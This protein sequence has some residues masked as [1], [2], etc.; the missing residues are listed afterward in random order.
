MSKKITIRDVAR[1]AGVS[2]SLVSMVLNAKRDK[3]GN[4]DC[5]VNKDTARKVIDVIKRLGYRPNKAAASLRS[6]RA[7]TIGVVVPDISNRF[8]SHLCRYIETVAAKEGY[9]VQFSSFDE[10]PDNFSEAIETYVGS[11]V[12]GLVVAPCLGGDAAIK[13]AVD[14][15]I[16][17]VLVDR[18]AQVEGVG[19]VLLDNEQAGRLIVGHL[20]RNGYKRIEI[21]ANNSGLSSIDK[22]VKGYIESMNKFGLQEYIAVHYVDVLTSYDDIL[23]IMSDAKKRGVE[24]IV[25]PASSL[26]VNGLKAA[27]TLKLKMPCDI[28]LVGFEENDLFLVHEPTVTHVYQSISEMGNRA[29]RMLKSMIEDK[30]SPSRIVLQPGLTEGGSSSPRCDAVKVDEVFPLLKVN[31]GN[32]ILASAPMFCDKGGWT[33]DSQYLDQMGS[34]C[35][36]AH[37]LGKPVE[38]AVTD[39]DVPVSGDYNLFVRTRNWTAPFTQAQTPGVFK[40][41]IDGKEVEA[42]FGNQSAEWHWQPGGSVFLA[43]GR[44]KLAVRDLTGFDGR[45]ASVLLTL[46]KGVPDSSRETLYSLRNNLLMLD[47]VPADKGEFDFVVAGGGVAGMCAA[48]AAARKGL[49]VALIQDRKVLGGNNSSEVRVG[50]GGRL[51]IG[52]YPSLG[53][54]LNEFGPATKGNARPFEVY[55]DDKKMDAVLK[56]KN[57]TLF[58]GYRV[59]NACK[60][61][62]R[63][64]RSVIAMQVDDYSRIEVKGRLFAD[65]TGD[66]CLGALAGAEWHMGRD[67]KSRYGEP[68]APEIEDG[69]TLG[70][71]VQWYSEEG[72]L[73]CT[74]PKIDWGIPVDERNVQVVRRGQW[75]WEVG[76][77]DDQIE[78]AERIRDYGMYVAYSNWSYL[79]NNEKY[80]DE[81]AKARLAWVSFIAGKRESR[82]LVGDYVLKEQDLKD[83][84]IYEDGTVSTSWYIDNHEPD[85]E[86]SRLFPGRE[87]LSRGHLTP[88]G[89]YPIPFR[90][91][92]SKDID[93]MMM[94]GRNISVS[95][96]ALG[97]V[98]VMRTT[99]MM[100]E[101]VGLAASICCKERMMPRDIH[102]RGFEKLSHLMQKGAGNTN[103]PYLQVYTL[104]DTTAARSEDC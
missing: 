64:I 2:T 80:R 97:T 81:Y 68:S 51:N 93:N 66:A 83:F 46:L 48:I 87:Y 91:F 72:D 54:L 98:R 14:A 44:H 78:D 86:N 18:E 23:P 77:R 50:L 38:D 62:P 79:K 25:L 57:I 7:Y 76:M 1:E 30:T 88:L 60:D 24:A 20:F 31:R 27:K 32:S 52:P 21:I 94:A 84:I 100:G 58:L 61:G 28:S 103:V 33:L 89:F 16:P 29:F 43:K 40:L 22:R 39:I 95:H 49:K 9:M 45:F 59:I 15:S 74:F 47:P 53:Y 6:G 26:S 13:R 42:V 35:I 82:R 67:P 8:F 102:Q 5:N 99:A 75:Y 101:V 104:I 4:L 19:S 73:P 37:G 56:E 17:V 34:T 36:L 10:N 90:C 69:I 65:C 71:S 92:C 63:M 96:I 11:G 3:D 55:E 85:P 12:E 70:A 41:F